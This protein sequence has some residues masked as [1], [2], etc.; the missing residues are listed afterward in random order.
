M[1]SED[2]VVPGQVTITYNAPNN[3]TIDPPLARLDR[4]VQTITWILVDKSGLNAEFKV[5]GGIVFPWPPHDEP[6]PPLKYSKW[7]PPGTDPV[8][9]ATTYSA[10]VNDKIPHGDKPKL[11]SYDIVIERDIPDGNGRTEETMH[12]DEVLRR[13]QIIDPPVENQPLP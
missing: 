11:Y 7:N 13:K 8:G 2:V 4:D 6:P 10:D 9:D 5:P 12:A 1:A 3:V